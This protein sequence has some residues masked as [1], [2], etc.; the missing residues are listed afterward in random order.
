MTNNTQLHISLIQTDIVWE[1]ASEN[2]NGLSKK[3]A[4]L[5]PKTDLVVLPEMFTTGFTMNVDEFAE[6]MDGE[7]ISWMQKIAF[8]KQIA[9][10]GSSII[11]ENNHYHNRLIFIH[12][13]GK[14]EFYDKRHSFTLAKE[15]ETFTSGT[16]KLLI[17]YK[18]WKICPLIC[19]DLRFPVWSRNIEN[20][21]VLI[22]VASWPKKRIYAWD[23]LLKARAIENMSYTI[24]VNRIGKDANN[25]EYN[26]HSIVLDCLGKN[27][28]KENNEVDEIISFTI[29]KTKQSSI[30]EKFSFLNDMDS[31]KIK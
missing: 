4:L 12:P 7:T 27:I 30:R 10:T 18:G 5:S 19:Y 25:F 21:D 24:G 28:S 3:I 26:G 6:T 16:K 1:N 8:E 29:D 23:N 14:I 9:I 22:Y 13:S 2:R 17:E 31:F 11:K 20:Y 15:E